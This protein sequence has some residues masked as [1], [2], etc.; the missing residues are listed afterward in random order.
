MELDIPLKVNTVEMVY[1]GRTWSL[2]QNKKENEEKKVDDRFS[3]LSLSFYFSFLNLMHTR[4]FVY[5]FFQSNKHKV[6]IWMER[7]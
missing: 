3:L 7:E 5:T 4:H 2:M 6:S 1:V